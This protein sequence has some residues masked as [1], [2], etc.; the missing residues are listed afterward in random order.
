[1]NDLW[2][3]VL[4]GSLANPARPGTV[5][6]VE[7]PAGTG[8]SHLVAGLRRRHPAGSGCLTL[9]C[10][11]PSDD[12]AQHTFDALDA[13]THALTHAFGDPTRTAVPTLLVVEDVHRADERTRCRIRHLARML[14]NG[15]AL[16]LTWRPENL[17]ADRPLLGEPL[18]CPPGT[19]VLRIRTGPLPAAAA[20][21]LAERTL[22]TRCPDDVIERL[23][24]VTGG[25]AQVLVDVLPV[26]AGTVLA[27]TAPDGPTVDA[28]EALEAPPRLA[29]TVL[30]RLAHLPSDARRLAHAA[31][32]LGEPASEAELAALTDLTAETARRM[33][34]A[35]LTAAVLTDLGPRRYGFRVPLAARAVAASL[36]APERA[37]LH[38]RAA[39][40]LRR[41]A[42]VPWPQ[43]AG[44]LLAAGVRRGLVRAAE[45]A[46]E[47]HAAAGQH[48]EAARL[49]Q[50]LLADRRIPGP[51]RARLA[52]AALRRIAGF[53]LQD[54]GALLDTLTGAPLLPGPLRAQA[55]VLQGLSLCTPTT[56]DHD[57]WLHLERA[58]RTL[59]DEPGLAARVLAA[60]SMPH[61]PGIPLAEHRQCAERAGAALAATTDPVLRA[62]VNANLVGLLLTLGDPGA[63][64]ALPARPLGED[65]DN[66][67]AASA[68]HRARALCNAA[69]ATLWLGRYH[70][71]LAFLERG[72]ALAGRHHAGPHVAHGIRSI[73]LLLDWATGR[74]TGLADRAAD[75]VA[76]TARTPVLGHEA[77]TVL[78]AL[79]LARGEWSQCRA[80]LA[81]GLAPHPDQ[82]L[83]PVAALS[84]TVLVR[85]ALARGDHDDARA[86]ATQA[87]GRLRSKGIWAWAAELAPW[88]VTAA[89]SAGDPA[90]ARTMAR[91]LRTAPAAPH[92]PLAAAARRWCRATLAEHDGDL[93]RAADGYRAAA[94]AYAA[95]PRP[96]MAALAAEAASHCA[97]GEGEGADRDTVD[98]LTD[99][100]LVLT[101]LGATHDAARVRS[102]LRALAPPRRGRPAHPG[103]SPRE[104]EVAEL[105]AGGLTNRQIAA[106][107]HLS[108]RTVE[109]HVARVLRKLSVPSR[110]DLPARL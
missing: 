20:R 49:L 7:G 38:H 63:E 67:D 105:A 30:R 37:D 13:L 48:R 42:D 72:A 22:G 23:Y 10:P 43:V 62:A 51:A 102:R 66:G 101:G 95:L 57:G 73:R 8:K 94:D 26:L 32:V 2:K 108:T 21:E 81:G 87:W 82:Q 75:L 15:C 35:A 50:D 90:T 19:A 4:H 97:A 68:G 86:H 71:S 25:V 104:R 40:V 12:D 109:N 1:M 18:T 92:L 65:E 54:A 91:D 106:A 110:R 11:G 3:A 33:L 107:L 5:L 96:Y 55:R 103:L 24:A 59:P 9:T 78:A 14:P 41:R 98:R 88:A 29:E 85:L 79:C 64:Q 60:M 83:A 99:A 44:H 46:A 52:T 76:D 36:P 80:W 84:S 77:R 56:P 39:Q 27:G 58:A 6:L 74:W 45:R 93:A 61:W 53:T 89:L 100:L 31:A 34:L 47:T 28:V 16:V 69:D 17:P 70:D